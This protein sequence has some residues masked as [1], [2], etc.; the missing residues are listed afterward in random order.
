ME[1]GDRGSTEELASREYHD[2]KV[3]FNKIIFLYI[4][5]KIGAEF[6]KIKKIGSY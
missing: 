2:L 3:F 4:Q 6:P 1:V 5:M